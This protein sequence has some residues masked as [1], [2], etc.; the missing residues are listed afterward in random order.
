[1]SLSHSVLK[2]RPSLEVEVTHKFENSVD[3]NYVI[4]WTEDSSVFVG[5]DDKKLSK[6]EKDFKFV[7]SLDL[8][9]KIYCAYT[10]NNLIICGKW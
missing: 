4:V 3:G 6:Y 2:L 10:L 1:M 5:G 8:K 9:S 7:D